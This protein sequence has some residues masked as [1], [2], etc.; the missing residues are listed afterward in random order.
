VF[1]FEFVGFLLF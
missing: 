1:D